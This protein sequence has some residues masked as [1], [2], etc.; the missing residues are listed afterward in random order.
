MPESKRL[1]VLLHDFRTNRNHM[2]VVADEYG[3]VAGLVT[4]EDILE[5]IVGE[6]EDEYDAEADTFIKPISETEFMVKALTPIEDFNEFF[7]CHLNDEEFDTIGGLI[8]Q[9]LGHMPKSN[10]SVNIDAFC[11]KVANADNRRIRLL[12]VSKAGKA[13]ES[14]ES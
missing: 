1:N 4:I 6:I 8:M 10:E 7:S 5:E 11:F 13:S 3:G 2:A 14:D 9:K 12:H